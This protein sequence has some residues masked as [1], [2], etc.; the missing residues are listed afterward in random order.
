MFFDRNF[1]CTVEILFAKNLND[2]TRSQD[3]QK[4]IDENQFLNRKGTVTLDHHPIEPI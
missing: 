4:N 3:T 2:A 1:T